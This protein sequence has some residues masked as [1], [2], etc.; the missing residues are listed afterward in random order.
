V[1]PTVW[2]GRNEAGR[3]FPRSRLCSELAQREELR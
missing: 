1:F 2:S 3:L